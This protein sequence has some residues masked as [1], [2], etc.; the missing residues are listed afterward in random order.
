MPVAV[1]F[2]ALA[3]AGAW[4]V[5]DV[6]KNSGNSFD[7]PSYDSDEGDLVRFEHTGGAP[8][9]VTSTQFSGGERLFSSA[10]IKSGSTAV[11]G[12][13]S[14]SPGTYPFICTIHDN[15]AA[16]LV[17]RES[18][19]PPPAPGPGPAPGEPEPGPGPGPLTLELGAKKQELT[20]K[21][22]FFATSSADSTLVAGGSVKQTTVQLAADEKTKVKAKLNRSQR[23]RLEEKLDR[24]GK[25]KAKVEATATDQS[26]AT[27]TDVVKV[28]LRD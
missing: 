15:M 23:E 2:L 4:G 17:V 24:S 7:K 14:L 10:T 3:P 27:A 9:N 26:G 8:H 22:K 20:K 5:A 18:A 6:I 13:E 25:A 16:E 12:T 1:T 21:L 19:A 28:K 11:N